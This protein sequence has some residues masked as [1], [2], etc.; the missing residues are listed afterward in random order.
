[1]DG[2]IVA[3]PRVERRRQWTPEEKAALVAEV[4]AEGGR[5]SVVARRHGIST[6]LL[7]NW[8]SAWRAVALAAQATAVRPAEFVH[9]GVVADASDDS[10]T[11]AGAVR[12]RGAGL[13]LAERVGV[14]EIDLPDGVRVRVDSGVNEKALRRVLLALRGPR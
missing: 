1:M 5:V 13:A 4:E 2:E 8:R 12:P 10:Q 3:A 9:L 11:A 7:Y 14:I 6:S